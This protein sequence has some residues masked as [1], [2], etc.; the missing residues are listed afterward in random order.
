MSPLVQT[1]EAIFK[2]LSKMTLMLGFTSI[3]ALLEENMKNRRAESRVRL[4]DDFR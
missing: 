1:E 3:H 4:V 2:E